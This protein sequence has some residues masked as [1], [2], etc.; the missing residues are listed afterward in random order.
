[1]SQPADR[2]CVFGLRIAFFDFGQVFF[3]AVLPHLMIL[4]PRLP[5]Y[6]I[7]LGAIS[8]AV[9]LHLAVQGP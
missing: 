4:N 2:G 1:M 8:S 5:F 7:A 9:L 3:S 6:S